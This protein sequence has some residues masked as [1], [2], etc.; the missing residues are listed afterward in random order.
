M[1]LSQE[2]I[3]YCMECGVCTG[4]CP[5]SGLLP[6]FSPRQMIKRVLIDREETVYEDPGLWACLTCARCS[7]RCP[8]QIDFPAFARSCRAVAREQGNQPEPAHHGIIQS[9]ASLQTRK[10][11]QQRTS[12]AEEVGQFATTGE[13]FF[14]VGC[15]PYFDA[16]LKYGSTAL[17]TSRSVLRLLNRM[18][19][20]PAMSDDERCCGHDAF[21]S[22]DTETFKKLAGMN[23]ET[24]AA[25]GAKTVLFNCPECYTIFKD[26]VPR[27][28]GKLP[29]ELLHITE[30]LTRKLP[31]SGLTFKPASDAN[32]IVTYQDPCRLGRK[33][34]IYE[35]PRE[36]LKLIPGL[37]LKEMGMNRENSLCCGT[38]AWMEC[39]GASK[40]MQ[41]ERLEEARYTGASTLITACPKCRIHFSCA[42]QNM[43]NGLNIEDLSSFL[44]NHIEQVD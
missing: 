9:I 41:V 34:S 32:R 19:I 22:G 17:D 37:E 35:E 1:K 27:F 7:S 15:A 39:T 26:E 44:L 11:S 6:A 18:G 30:F 40:A 24:I 29:F 14:F 36:L 21:W 5:V 10:V 42:G 16:A 2:Q 20:V 13:V 28:F 31:E 38:S 33:A 8:A 23:L 4:S 12:W 25:S 43:E 3:A